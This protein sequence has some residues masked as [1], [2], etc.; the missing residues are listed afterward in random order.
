MALPWRFGTGTNTSSNANFAQQVDDDFAALAAEI[1]APFPSQAFAALPA[2]PVLGMVT[3][4][5]NSTT[6]TWGA[7]IAGGGGNTVLAWY[8]G[9]HWT[10]I[11]A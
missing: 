7:T 6:A 8:N 5:N 4:V 10:V 3:V 2:S 11:G 9:V 1:A